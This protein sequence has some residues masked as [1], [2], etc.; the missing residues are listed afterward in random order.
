MNHDKILDE[1]KFAEEHGA[2]L[3]L[4]SDHVPGTDGK[5]D[6]VTDFLSGP[7]WKISRSIAE[8]ELPFVAKGVLSVQDA[9]KVKGCRL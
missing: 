7:L 2:M 9:V 6:V 8:T 4:I 3:V 5:Y 1:I